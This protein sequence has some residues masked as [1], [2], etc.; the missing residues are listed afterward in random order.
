MIVEDVKQGAASLFSLW[1]CPVR[2]DAPEVDT[3]K[4][5]E[6]YYHTTHRELVDNHYAMKIIFIIITTIK[7]LIA[8]NK[9]TERQKKLI[10][11]SGQRPLKS[12]LSKLIFAHK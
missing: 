4:G 5:E 7:A 8:I 2:D 6:S 9:Y 1:A 12:T 10:T 3:E 11:S